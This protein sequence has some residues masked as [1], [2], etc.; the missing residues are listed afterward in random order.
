MEQL[1]VCMRALSQIDLS[2][3][4]EHMQKKERQENKLKLENSKL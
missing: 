3:M 2:E 4:K 1:D